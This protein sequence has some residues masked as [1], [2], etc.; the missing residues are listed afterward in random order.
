MFVEY[1]A[2]VTSRVGSVKRTVMYFSKLV[3]KPN[4][5]KFSFRKVKELKR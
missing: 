5:K 2:K 3:C 1:E 4:K